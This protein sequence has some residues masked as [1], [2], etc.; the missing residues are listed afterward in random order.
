[1]ERVKREKLSVFFQTET[2]QI[3]SAGEVQNKQEVV[4]LYTVSSEALEFAKMAIKVFIY[5]KRT[6][7]DLWKTNVEATL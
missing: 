6:W 4:C 2:E 3:K 7:T 5:S 1:M